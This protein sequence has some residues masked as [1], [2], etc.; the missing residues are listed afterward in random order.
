M[1]L[2]LD[3]QKKIFEYLKL[4]EKENIINIPSNIKGIT[5]ELPPKNQNADMSCNASMILAKFNKT[6][7]LKLAETIKKHLLLSQ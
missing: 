5:A 7:P 1:N 4:L 3:Y 6:S 2:F